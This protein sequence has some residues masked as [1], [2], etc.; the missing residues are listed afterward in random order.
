MKK[1]TSILALVLFLLLGVSLLSSGLIVQENISLQDLPWSSLLIS[2]G[3]S[4]IAVMIST[5]IWSLVGGH[6][7]EK[8]ISNFVSK[9]KLLSC[10]VETGLKDLL[11]RRKALTYDDINQRIQKAKVVE[12]VS[13][14][15]KVQQSEDL[16]KSLKECVENGGS[17]RIIVSDPCNAGAD[18]ADAM[19]PLAIREFA[20]GDKKRG[21]M[22]AEIEETLHYLSDINEDLGCRQLP[23]KIKVKRASNHVLYS[24]IIRVDDLMWVSHYSNKRR[25]VDSPTLVI[26]QSGTDMCLHKFYSDEFQYLW[27]ESV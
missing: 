27:K 13:L 15:F 1:K 10:G 19:D 6:P 20:E 11:S 5:V 22:R 17:V 16:K 23:S 12:I 18:Q 4:L 14:V 26:H 24:S 25:G 21:R 8:E 9:S 3:A 2:L 7:I